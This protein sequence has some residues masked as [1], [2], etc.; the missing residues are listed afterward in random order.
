MTNS[1]TSQSALRHRHDV[2]LA[3]D[4]APLEFSLV[5]PTYNERENI[6]VV[7]QRLERIL[8]RHKFEVIL[9]DDDSPDATWQAAQALQPRYPWLRVIRRR[10]EQNLSS[11][12]VSGFRHAR[13]EILG[14]MQA[15]LRADDTQLPELLR[16][17]KYVDFAVA[18]RNVSDSK[19][20]ARWPRRFVRGTARLLARL[21][22]RVPLSDPTS[23]F[24]VMRR[25]IFSAIDDWALNPSGYTLLV[26]LY[27]RAIQALGRDQV[28]LSEIGYSRR[29]GQLG[30]DKF[31]PQS[32]FEFLG[33]LF[34]VRLHPRHQASRPALLPVRS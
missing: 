29:A 33:T 31:S 4:N 18:T 3:C 7:L 20:K 9:V 14:V 5:L 1:H 32:V 24:F 23:G 8:A 21:I 27:A 26:Y 15:D 28:R 34:D 13:G 11:A 22:A 17:I 6:V 30:K 25:E 10:G 19:R 16:T 12:I 2:D